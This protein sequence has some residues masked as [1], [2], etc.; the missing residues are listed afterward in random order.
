M[1]INEIYQYCQDVAN[2]DM[3]G[4]AFTFG[5]FNNL[6]AFE[7]IDL[8]Q[9]A[10]TQAQALAK[11]KRVD[12]AEAIWSVSD[13]RNFI[14]TES[15][16][17]RTG[18]VGSLSVGRANYPS[19]FQYPIA[20][21]GDYRNVEIL[22]ISQLGR[23]RSGVLGRDLSTSP[24]AFCIDGAFEY[25]PNDLAVLALTYLKTPNEPYCDFCVS[26][27]DLPVFMPEDSYIVY[28]AP[29]GQYCLYESD[30]TL[31]EAGVTHT[32][33]EGTAPSPS[34]SYTSLT[35]ELEWDATRHIEIANRILEKVGVNMRSPEVTQYAVSQ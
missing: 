34:V 1:T 13:L 5:Q 33:F 21:M 32:Y 31:I 24:V 14:K 9:K 22:S 23:V 35:T 28:I 17:P 25:Y 26:A 6:I 10:F 29:K 7:N 12:L 27:D 8:F 3:K 30:G 16:S 4:L 11:E 20:L 19:D 18:L 15:L 2:K